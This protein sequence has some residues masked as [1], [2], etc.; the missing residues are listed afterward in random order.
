MRKHLK[1]GV[2]KESQFKSDYGTTSPFTTLF[3]VSTA[4]AGANK[5]GILKNHKV[6]VKGEFHLPQKLLFNERY[7]MTKYPTRRYLSKQMYLLSRHT[8]LLIFLILLANKKK[9]FSWLVVCSFLKISH[10]HTLRTNF[11][12]ILQLLSILKTISL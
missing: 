8:F 12:E 1:K 10:L 7:K 5:W 2:D 11:H 3:C 6:T 4:G 9:L